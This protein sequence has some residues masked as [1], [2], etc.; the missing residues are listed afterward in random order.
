M[1]Q[2]KI[3]KHLNSYALSNRSKRVFLID[4]DTQC[5][6]HIN[7]KN[8]CNK[9]FKSLKYNNEEIDIEIDW[10]LSPQF[11]LEH[12][13][14]IAGQSSITCALSALVQPEQGHTKLTMYVFYINAQ[15]ELEEN[16]VTF[17]MDSVNGRMSKRLKAALEGFKLES[18]RV[19]EGI[20]LNGYKQ[21]PFRTIHYY[22]SYLVRRAQVI[23]DQKGKWEP[24]I[25]KGCFRN[26]NDTSINVML[27]MYSL[28]KNETILNFREIKDIND[29]YH[30]SDKFNWHPEVFRYS[31]EEMNEMDFIVDIYK[32][33][34]EKILHILNKRYNYNEQYE[35]TDFRNVLLTMMGIKNDE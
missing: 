7:Y 29:F 20:K 3:F 32:S 1:Y 35:K 31:Q 10:N 6:Y 27:H 23:D 13:S 9:R 14:T 4:K 19:I 15:Q 30:R 18:L 33:N 21:C 5:H 2:D 12:H 17:Y 28:L 24:S 11:Y 8:T 26:Y 34:Y 25:I 22:A 16:T